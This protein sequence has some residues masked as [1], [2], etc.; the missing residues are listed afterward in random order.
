MTRE[1]FMRD[2]APELNT[3]DNI[4]FQSY[5]TIEK[6]LI[7]GERVWSVVAYGSKRYLVPGYATRNATGRY[8]VTKNC[9][10]HLNLE[11]RL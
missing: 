8:V 11:V 9:W 4:K 7:P 6:R 2:Y 10:T 3:S 1:E 5:A